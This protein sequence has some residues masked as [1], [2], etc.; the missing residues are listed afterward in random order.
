MS[1]QE[2]YCNCSSVAEN[3]KKKMKKINND[4]ATKLQDPILATA[5]EMTTISN[6][7]RDAAMQETLD[8]IVN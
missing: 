7:S 6:K 5:T 1:E 2:K 8:V 3:I 4:H